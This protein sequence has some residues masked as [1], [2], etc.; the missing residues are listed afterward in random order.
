MPLLEV[1]E[2]RA[3]KS[4][5]MPPGGFKSEALGASSVQAIALPAIPR[6]H[7]LLQVTNAR[8][9]TISLPPRRP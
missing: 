7:D 5:P 8:G 4:G 6:D 1:Q 2:D 9:M 3:A